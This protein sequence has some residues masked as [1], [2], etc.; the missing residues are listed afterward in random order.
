[1]IIKS[2]KE[3]ITPTLFFFESYYLL[4]FIAFILEKDKHLVMSESMTSNIKY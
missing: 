1:M 4:I 3:K 2:K